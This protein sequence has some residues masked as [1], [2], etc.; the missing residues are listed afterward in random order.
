V[1]EKKK[2]SKEKVKLTDLDL[3]ETLKKCMI[4][5]EIKMKRKLK[6][7]NNS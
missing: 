6:G 3:C 1:K 5:Q 7:T 2:R 4:K